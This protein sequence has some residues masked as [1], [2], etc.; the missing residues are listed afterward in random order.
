MTTLPI[1]R[2]SR[3]VAWLFLTLATL[4]IAQAEEPAWSQPRQPFRIY[5]NTW[6][7]GTQ[8]LSAILITSP[9]GH[10]LIDGTLPRN[11]AQIEANIRALG[12]KLRD[13]RVILNSHA[14]ADHAG[15]I[16]RL[17]RDSGAQ[18]WASSNG[19]RAL[20]AGGNDPD[21]P[22]YGMAPRYPAV[23]HV[24]VIR[25]G[26]RV[27]AGTITVTAH[28]TPGHTPGSTSWTWQSCE[29]SR[30]LAMVY[31]DSLT[32]LGSRD[33]RFTD[34]SSHPHRVEDF[35]HSIARVGALPC[36]VLLTP[37]PDAS[38]FIDK[39]DRRGRSAQADPLVDPQ[40]CRNYA[41]GARER[42]DG[43]LRQEGRTPH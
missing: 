17:A 23:A 11:A 29:G 35:R 9:G 12:F 14:H 25:D 36:D 39:A 3:I 38:G 34:D 32:A 43:L 28:Y 1:T 20:K 6:Y 4:G 40:A 33:Y 19:A 27:R 7:V 26:G 16:A 21:D 31:A 15:A 5:G 30:C 22:Q 2:W 18:V 42:F 37:H 41:A 13:V 10:V 8:G 24:A